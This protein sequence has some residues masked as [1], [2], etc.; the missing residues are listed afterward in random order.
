[1][2]QIIE[3]V[4]YALLLLAILWVVLSTTIQRFKCPK[5]TETELFL[6]IPKSII[7]NWESC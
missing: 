2:K 1:M 4:L 6:R 7:G 3:N 5:M